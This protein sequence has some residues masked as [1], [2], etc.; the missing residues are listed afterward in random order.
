MAVRKRA[1]YLAAALTLGL[2][3]SVIPL[4]AK[5]QRKA[6]KPSAA[7]LAA[8][9]TVYA[10]HACAACHAIA[11]T[12]SKAGPDLTRTGRG[13]TAAWMTLVIRDPKKLFPRGTMPAYGSDRIPDKD[14]KAL[15]AYMLSLK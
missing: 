1:V 2:A 4:S 8:G 6:P 11:G 7:V 5:G 12:G 15:V 3:C 13:R 10:K 9:K 14:L